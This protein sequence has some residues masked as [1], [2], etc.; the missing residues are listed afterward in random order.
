M[1]EPE[2]EPEP[3]LEGEGQEA[4]YLQAVTGLPQLSTL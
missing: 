2:S 1:A 4:S 3:E